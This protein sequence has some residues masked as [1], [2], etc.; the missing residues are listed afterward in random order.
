[1]KQDET[2]QPPPEGYSSEVASQTGRALLG[3]RECVLRGEFSRGE[4]ISEVAISER[5]QMSRTPIRMALGTFDN[6]ARSQE[7][8]THLAVLGA[9]D[10]NT[11]A[12]GEQVVTHLMLTHLREGVTENDALEM[13]SSLGLSP[14]ILY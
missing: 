1:M 7:I 14:T 12:R 13:A 4:R 3:I 9:I 11:I 10:V 2:P 8:A 5:L 6:D